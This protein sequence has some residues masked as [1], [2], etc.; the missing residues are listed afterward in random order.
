MPDFEVWIRVGSIDHY[1]LNGRIPHP[2]ASDEGKTYL[3][4]EMKTF[5]EG[6]DLME[7]EFDCDAP[8]QFFVVERPGKADVELGTYEVDLVVIRWMGQVLWSVAGGT[9]W[10]KPNDDC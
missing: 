3:V 5:F 4:K 9:A 1:G 8:H 2:E 10:T 7:K 6:P